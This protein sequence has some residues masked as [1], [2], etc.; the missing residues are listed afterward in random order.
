MFS[1]GRGF[2]VPLLFLLSVLIMI[3]SKEIGLHTAHVIMLVWLVVC[4][5]GVL[6]FGVRSLRRAASALGRPLRAYEWVIDSPFAGPQPFHSF[7]FIQAPWWS[8]VYAVA[9][10][11]IATR[12]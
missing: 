7:M 10:F 4:G 9:A 1:R 2:L 12:L 5:A 6:G 8:L 3:P 11:N